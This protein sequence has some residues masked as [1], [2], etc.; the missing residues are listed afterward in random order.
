MDITITES[1]YDQERFLLIRRTVVDEAG[2]VHSFLERAPKE[3]VAIRAAE[4]N[5]E[6]DDDFVLE[7]VLLEPFL[8]AVEGPG[9][10]HPLYSADSVKD[11]VEIMRE[12]VE[13]ARTLHGAPKML[14]AKAVRK[15]VASAGLVAAHRQY[16]ESADPR[17]VGPIR[18]MR[19]A[20]R[21]R[22]SGMTHVG[23][24][25]YLSSLIGHALNN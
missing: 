17:I 11:A 14:M 4:Y 19:D 25:D 18:R 3:T 1:A 6:P 15:G 23:E 20:E 22:L 8:P 5:L 10:V 16:S 9:D 24:Q 7:M 13:L 21:E 2:E 12:R